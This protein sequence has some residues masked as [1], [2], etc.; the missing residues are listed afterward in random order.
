VCESDGF[1]GQP[2]APPSGGL[3]TTR[4]SVGDCPAFAP[5]PTNSQQW[6]IIAVSF[7][8]DDSADVLIENVSG[9]ENGFGDL[10]SVCNEQPNCVFVH[11]DTSGLQIPAGGM[12][13]VNV[14]NTT[15]EGGELAIYTNNLSIPHPVFCDL[16]GRA[17]AFHIVQWG[18]GPAGDHSLLGDA[19][20]DFEWWTPGD[21]I[22][23]D[24]GDTGFSVIGATDSEDGFVSCNPNL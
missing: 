15:I 2:A 5:Q 10:F 6:A 7:Q 17:F 11:E 4:A 18:L 24:A 12:V 14:P 22:T 9:A 3:A 1:S 23:I 20:R 8:P 21:L 19:N 16:F 13:E